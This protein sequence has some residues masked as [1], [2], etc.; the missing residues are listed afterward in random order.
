[1]PEPAYGGLNLIA[2]AASSGWLFSVVDLARLAA[3][4]D[5][6]PVYPD[7]ISEQSFDLMTTSATPFGAPSM[8]AAWYLDVDGTGKAL[9]WDHAGEMPGTVARIARLRSGVIVVVASNTA[10]GQEYFDDITI[11]LVNAVNGISEWPD[12]DLFPSYD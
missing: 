7:I 9:A 10:R 4:T 8:G 1:V 11:G 6:D 5:G 2:F 12:V 3:A